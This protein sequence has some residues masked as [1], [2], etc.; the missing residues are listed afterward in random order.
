MASTAENAYLLSGGA[1]ELER[2]RLQARVWEPAAEQLLDQ[3]GIAPGSQC[4]DLGCGGMGILGPLSRR[5][6]PSGQVV[7]VDRDAQQLAAARAYVDEEL[8]TNVEILDTDAYAT[9]LPDSSFDLVHVRF[10]F[11]PVGR[12][13]QLL[14]EML[15]LVRPRGII[16]IQEPDASAWACHPPSPAWGALKTAIL[17]AFK[18][19]GGDFDAGVR[20]FGLLRSAG[21]ENVQVRTAV[22]ALQDG[23]PYMRLPIQ[24]A[25]SLRQRILDGGFLAQSELDEHIAACEEMVRDPATSV[26]TFILTQVWGHAPRERR[27]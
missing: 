8:L 14:A 25:T 3:I 24:F 27:P 6:G 22:L 1:A 12:N 9:G 2:L 10:L 4:L 7:G 21:I 16:A 20:T 23:H 19:G 11:A 5:A 18:A 13:D 26:T 15:R 17:Q